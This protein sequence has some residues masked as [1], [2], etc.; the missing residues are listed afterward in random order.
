MNRLGDE[1]DQQVTDLGHK[2]WL[3][4]NKQTVSMENIIDEFGDLS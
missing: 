4:D 2:R 1:Y 3:A